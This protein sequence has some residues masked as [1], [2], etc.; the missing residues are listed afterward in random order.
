V[1]RRR[2]GHVS[3]GLMTCGAAHG[4]LRGIEVT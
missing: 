3:A 1:M 4:G 2:G